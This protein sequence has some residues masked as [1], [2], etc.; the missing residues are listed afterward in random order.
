M[1]WSDFQS[2]Y[3]IIRDDQLCLLYRGDFADEVTVRLI[4]LSDI[5]FR[6]PSDR[7]NMRK[8]VAFLMAECFQN[9][10]RHSEISPLEVGLPEYAGFFMTRNINSEYYIASGNL[11]ENQYIP[12]LQ[13]KIENINKLSPGELKELY[14][15]VL[16]T[17]E[18]SA[19]G[20]AGLGLIEMARRSGRKLESQFRKINEKLSYFYI[21]ILIAG[22]ELNSPESTAN[23]CPICNSVEI[24]ELLTRNDVLMA[25][26]GDFRQDAILPLLNMI[27]RNI[28]NIQKES[29]LTKTI[30]HVLVE[31]LQN[32]MHH[33]YAE[34]DKKE[35][36]FSIAVSNKRFNISTANYVSNDKSLYLKEILE[37]FLTHSNGELKSLY[38]QILK[39]GSQNN[40]GGAGLGLID[41]IRASN[42]A[43]EYKLVRIDNS[44]SLFYLNVVI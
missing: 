13:T 28:N 14:I 19:K 23:N 42:I 16:G 18:I 44:K 27:N 8:K 26:H 21:Q 1:N 34:N 29:Y 10:I 9:V 24:N 35:G 30:F 4:D 38:K 39:G 31:M 17:D 3:S 32:I 33:G 12:G 15:K 40:E 43:P 20:G 36:I 5:Q 37:D 11:V 25:Y 6:G 41:I 22:A 7:L 2:F